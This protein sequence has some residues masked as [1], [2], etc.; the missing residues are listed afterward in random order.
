LSGWD[1]GFLF[2]RE[3]YIQQ[4]EHNNI[5][6]LTEQNWVNVP[7]K[8]DRYCLIGLPEER[9]TVDESGSRFASPTTFSLRKLDE[10]PDC[11][12]YHTD[13]IFYASIDP[14]ANVADITG[15]SGG[16]ILGVKAT[17]DEEAPYWFLAIQGGWKKSKR[18]IYASPINYLRAS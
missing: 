2:L 3:H 14:H 13:P 8:F 16:L 5:I 10:K 6:Q 12:S 11:F 15:M 4:F 1:F 17:K 18:L 7:G 9:I